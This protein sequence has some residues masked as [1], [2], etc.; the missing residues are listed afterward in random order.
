MNEMMHFESKMQ[1]TKFCLLINL[2][3]AVVIYY[4][5]EM[6]RLMGLKE[7]PLAIS[8]IWPATGFSLA[9]LLLFGYKTVPGI[10]LGNF[11]YNFFHLFISSQTFAGPFITATLVTTGSVTEAL[12]AFYILRKY[13]TSNYFFSVKD[14]VIFLLP[15][16]LLTSL[17]AGVIGVM[18]LYLFAHLP[19]QAVLYTAITFWMG[20]CM[21]MYVF[22]PL[23]VVWSILKFSFPI[24]KYLKEIILMILV[25]MIISIL[26]FGLNYPVLHFYTPLCLWIAYRFYMHGATAAIFF[27]TLT[28]VIPTSLGYG[29]LIHSTTPNTLLLT[30][31]FLNILVATSLIFAAVLNE[32]ENCKFLLQNQKIDFSHIVDEREKEE[33]AKKESVKAEKTSEQAKKELKDTV[34]IKEKLTSLGLLTAGMGRQLQKPL[35]KINT[36][37]FEALQ[38]F[39][40]DTIKNTLNL[41]EEK[42]NQSLNIAKIIHEQGIL[43]ARAK[44]KVKSFDINTLITSI[45]TEILSHQE[46]PDIIFSIFHEFDKNVNLSLLFHEDLSQAFAYLL[47]R[48]LQSLKEKKLQLGLNYKPILIIKTKD[49]DK[50]IEVII[51]DNGMGLS[52][53]KIAL[54][55][56]TFIGFEE[57]NGE[58]ID[59]TLIHDI[60]V[61]VYQGEIKVESQEGEYFQITVIL[62]K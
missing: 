51:R 61:H 2:F 35:K 37:V 46:D 18:S 53:E 28:I 12:L 42:V 9:A 14:I 54:F 52:E 56:S 16:T 10:F 39:S 21:G 13:N 20:D 17:I 38:S 49:L 59:L 24:R 19:L 50:H 22:T 4:N 23:L 1:T 58:G 47:E 44:L 40:T 27:I 31:T 26:V 41:I 5:A 55:F 29:V 11:G 34:L 6:G 25:F 3:L 43:I 33:Q 30:I 36:L 45:L 48:A 57:S 7:P 60:L 62:P 15:A 8:V 32:R